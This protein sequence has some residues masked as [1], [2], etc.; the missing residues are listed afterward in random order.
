MSDPVNHPDHYNN[1][2]S[3]CANCGETIEAIQVTE[4]MNFNLGNAVKYVWRAGKKGD[5]LEDLKKAAWYL[6]REIQ[7]LEGEQVDKAV[8]VLKKQAD[9]PAK[10]EPGSIVQ[11]HTLQ[12]PKSHFSQFWVGPNQKREN[13]GK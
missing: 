11:Y 10:S 2:P 13:E 8:E 12:V 6:N 4:Q 5:R 3:K 7:R 1:G 9:E